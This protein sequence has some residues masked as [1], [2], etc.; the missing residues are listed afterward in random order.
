MSTSELI[1]NPYSHITTFD[2]NGEIIGLQIELPVPDKSKHVFQIS[3][4]DNA[5]LVDFIVNLTKWGFNLFEADDLTDEERELLLANGFLVE[6]DKSPEKP[7]FAY[8]VDE[9][10]PQE[11]SAELLSAELIVNPSLRFEPFSLTNVSHLIQDNNFSP[12]FPTVWVEMP[13]TEIEMGYWLRNEYID[14][15]EHLKPGEKLNFE[16][17][18]KVLLKLIEAEILINP[19]AFQAKK[20]EVDKN[21][22]RARERFN[23]EKYV[24]LE[25][26]LPAYYMPA[27]KKFFRQYVSNGFMPF[28]D[29]QVKRRFYQHNLPLAQF[30]HQNF[31]KLMSK[32]VGS[33]VIPSYVYAASYIEDAFLDPHIDREQCEYSISFQVDYLPEPEN[34]ISPWGLYVSPLEEK[35]LQYLSE[36]GH[37]PWEDYPE[38]DP[39]NQKRKAFH[40]RSGDGLF[41]K[42]RELVH[43]RYPLP[44][45]HKSTSLFFHYVDKD[46]GGILH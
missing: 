16:L 30:F 46:F 37:L 3:S 15:V 8:F 31:T 10:E 36:H 5:D 13:A 43:Y 6:K 42:G 44:K 34:D 24:V 22:T 12:H 1:V 21:L 7:L 35:E 33:E 2:H 20:V 27:M 39:T 9:I 19:E 40:L 11:S 45:E 18:E 25:E 14:I 41:Y 28:N 26:I 4:E 32:I 23:T 38:D 29:T 17:D